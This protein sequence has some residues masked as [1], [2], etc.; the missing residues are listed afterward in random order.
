[1]KIVALILFFILSIHE[2]SISQWY[3]QNNGTI[4]T[5][6]SI[7]FVDANTGWSCGANGTILKTT[8]GGINWISQTSNTFAELISLFFINNIGWACEG[9]SAL[10]K[11]TN[12]GLNWVGYTSSIMIEELHFKDSLTGWSAGNTLGS[13]SIQKTTNCGIPVEFLSFTSTVLMNDVRLSWATAT[14]KNNYG[15]N[16]EKIENGNL[17]S[18]KWKT[19]SFVKGLGTT[20]EKQIYKFVDED[21]LPGKY[22]YR[23]KQVDYDGTSEY[24]QAIEVEL[25]SPGVFKLEQNYPNPFNPSTRI[26]DPVASKQHITLKIFDVLGNEVATL[27]D[28]YKPAESYEVKFDGS[29]HSTGIYLYQLKADNFIQSKNF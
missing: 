19:I 10:L 22:L 11:T 25:I 7:Y 15:L 23:L 29:N 3:P 27:V 1:M 17:S 9:L 24:S 26:K 21:L 18:G 20:T 4:N 13:F 2:N 6:N 16:V 8:N 12:G 5:L 28:E 14:E